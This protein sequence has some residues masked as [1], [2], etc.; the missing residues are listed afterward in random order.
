MKIFLSCGSVCVEVRWSWAIARE[1]D[2]KGW[3]WRNNNNTAD[4]H[5][6]HLILQILADDSHQAIIII[7]IIIIMTT[8]DN[9]T[10]SSC[11]YHHPTDN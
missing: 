10:L 9:W 6:H 8:L 1:W 3:Q 7:I 11:S 4:H 2:D 5:S